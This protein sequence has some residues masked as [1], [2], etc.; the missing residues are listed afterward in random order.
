VSPDRFYSV[1]EHT[2]DIGIEIQVREEAD[3]F[4]TAA[5]A[6]F[7]L[8]FGLDTIAGSEGRPIEATGDTPGELLVAWLNEVLYV[9]AAEQLVFH[10][11]VDV[12]LEEGRF[13]A[14]G[15]GEKVDPARHVGE[16]EIKAATYHGLVFERAAGGWRAR[17]IF[18]V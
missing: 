6:M 9:Q 11:F 16:M 3:V 18:D 17:I 14:R 10:D 5:R 8:M 7:D 12:R 4:V 15:V 1:V 13:S 2:A